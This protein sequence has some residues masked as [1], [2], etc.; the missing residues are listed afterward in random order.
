[1]RAGFE[2]NI[3]GRLGEQPLVGYRGNGIYLGMRLSVT[4]VIP[5]ADDTPL[6][7]DHRPHHGVGRHMSAPQ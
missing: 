3:E 4:T 7:H 2:R 1:M 6:V 5:L